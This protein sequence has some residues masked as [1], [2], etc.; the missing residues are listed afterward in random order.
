[1]NTK[2]PFDARVGLKIACVPREYE[3]IRQALRPAKGARR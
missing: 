1:M 2:T 3:S